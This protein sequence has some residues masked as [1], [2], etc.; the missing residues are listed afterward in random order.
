MMWLLRT[1]C[2][3]CAGV[4]KIPDKAR[5][6]LVNDKLDELRGLLDSGS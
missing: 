1:V 4:P 3:V 2:G 5:D 6:W